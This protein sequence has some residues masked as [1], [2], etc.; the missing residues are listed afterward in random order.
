M[1]CKTIKKPI[2]FIGIGLHKGKPVKIKL[3]PLFEKKIVFFRQ[4]MGISIELSPFN[5]VDTILATVIGKNNAVISTIEHL[6]SAVYAF[7]IDGLRIIVDGDEIPIMDGSSFPFVMLLKEANF[8]FFSEKKEILKIIKPIEVR[9]GDKFVKVEPSSKL[10]FDYTIEFDHPLIKKQS[11]SFEFSTVKY[12]NEISR[13]RTFGFLKDIQY[14]KNKGFIQGGNLDNAV[15]L[16]KNGILNDHLRYKDEFVRHKILDAIGDL[17]QLNYIFLGKY[18][19]F[20]GSHKLNNLL[21]KKIIAEKAYEII[22][23]T[24]SL[25]TFYFNKAFSLNSLTS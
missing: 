14:L 9:D 2:Q 24:N 6:M 15:V 20:K 7:G 1:F 19:A 17:S 21:C 8:E 23:D 12:I 22:T 10:I 4:D 5:I 3:A 25:S 18:T 16:T 13:A 11:Y